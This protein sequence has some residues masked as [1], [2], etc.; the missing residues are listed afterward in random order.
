V[1]RACPNSDGAEHFIILNRKNPARHSIVLGKEKMPAWDRTEVGAHL[2]A[3]AASRGSS[4]S[5]HL[6]GIGS[7]RAL[8]EASAFIANRRQAYHISQR[9]SLVG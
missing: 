1:A 3:V 7:S 6:H 9:T 5:L 4:L 2:A 8:I